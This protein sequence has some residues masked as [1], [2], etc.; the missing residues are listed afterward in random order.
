MQTETMPKN[1]IKPEDD[2]LDY[3]R[4]LQL[5]DEKL[6]GNAE[7]ARPSHGEEI[8]QAVSK[9]DPS[10]DF[11]K[12]IPFTNMINEFAKLIQ[13]EKEA[14]LRQ[15]HYRDFIDELRQYSIRRNCDLEKSK[16]NNKQINDINK[17]ASKIKLEIKMIEKKLADYEN[18]EVSMDELDDDKGIYCN[19]HPKLLQKLKRLLHKLYELQQMPLIGAAHGLRKFRF[20]G[21]EHEPLNEAISAMLNTMLTEHYEEKKRTVSKMTTPDFPQV[22]EL[23]KKVNTQHK[24]NLHPVE[25]SARDIFALIGQELKRRRERSFNDALHYYELQCKEERLKLKSLDEDPELQERLRGNDTLKENIESYLEK[26][27]DNVLQTE[28]DNQTE[29]QEDE[30][31]DSESDSETRSEDSLST[32]ASDTELLQDGI[33]I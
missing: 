13:D 32:L 16:L 5:L 23:V 12:D 31:L 24:L 19:K 8:K 2:W 18:R 28:D 14:D 29:E 30:S 20:R 9:L 10:V 11:A 4:F 21:C 15:L 26:F 27:A 7:L 33:K 17:K 3:E 25:Q 6:S 22:L 1:G